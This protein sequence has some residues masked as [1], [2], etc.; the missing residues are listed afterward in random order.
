MKKQLQF[1]GSPAVPIPSQDRGMRRRL[2]DYLN[3]VDAQLHVANPDYDPAKVS[4]KS[5]R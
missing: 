1:S 5:R 4:A 2:M 3:A